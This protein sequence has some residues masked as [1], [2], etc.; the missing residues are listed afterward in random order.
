MLYFLFAVP[1]K[2]NKSFHVFF[3]LLIFLNVI[4]NIN[5]YSISL[6]KEEHQHFHLNFQFLN[7]KITCFL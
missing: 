3:I 1:T 6:V 2:E 5:F 4:N 7:N